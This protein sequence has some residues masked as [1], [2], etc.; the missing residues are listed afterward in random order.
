MRPMSPVHEATTTAVRTR[1]EPWERLVPLGASLWRLSWR[2]T[3][4]YAASR[5]AVLLTMGIVA[6]VNGGTL[7]GRID[8]WDSVWYLQA[9][10]S[11]Y[12]AH[13]PVVGG[14]VVANTLAFIPGLPLA[15]RAL[16]ASTGMSQ[17]AAGVAIS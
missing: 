14:H 3:V 4:A 8:R 6:A 16:A 13:L 17:F 11:G 10:A 7:A 5:I 15:I 1:R 2:P 9:A 12:R